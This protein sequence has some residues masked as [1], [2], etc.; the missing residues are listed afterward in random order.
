M[1]SK[2]CEA[3]TR[4]ARI[5]GSQ[6]VVSL[7]SRLESNTEEEVMVSGIWFLVSAFGFDVFGFGS[8]V[9]G[10][11]FATSRGAPSEVKAGFVSLGYGKKES[12]AKTNNSGTTPTNLAIV[13]S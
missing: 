11:G 5:Q 7:N 6:M 8:R 2:K 1:V 13:L 4:R 10:S 3:V 9:D 12:M